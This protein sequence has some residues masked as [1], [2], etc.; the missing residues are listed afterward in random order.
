MKR[1][2]KWSF[3]AQEA[4]RLAALGLTPYAIAKRLGVNAST[5]TRWKHAGKLDVKLQP[6]KPTRQKVPNPPR[7]TKTPESWAIQVRADYDLDPTDDQ[8][9]TLAQQALELAFNMAEAPAVRLAASARFQAIE[10][11]LS[12]R[13]RSTEDEKPEAETPVERPAPQPRP[14]RAGGDPR[15]LF[16][17]VPK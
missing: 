9:V 3:V 5:V 15:A 8:L 17:V 16:A 2:R 13:L 10:K 12:L 4:Q 6:R 14:V 11:R 1:T 7:G